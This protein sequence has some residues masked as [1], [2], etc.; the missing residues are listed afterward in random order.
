M[1]IDMHKLGLG[2]MAGGP[3]LIQFGNSKVSWWTGFVCTVLGPVLMA[4]R[5]DKR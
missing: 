4:L 1:N 2:L 5:K 3:V